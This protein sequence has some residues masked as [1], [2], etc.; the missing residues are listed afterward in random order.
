MGKRVGSD[1]IASVHRARKIYRLKTKLTKRKT[2]L[3][4][5][6]GYFAKIVNDCILSIH[7]LS[8]VRTGHAQ[9]LCPPRIS[10]FVRTARW[11]SEQKRTIRSYFWCGI[12]ALQS[13]ALR[14]STWILDPSV[15]LE[16]Q[17][18]IQV[19]GQRVDLPHTFFEH[20]INFLIIFLL[21]YIEHFSISAR[22]GYEH[23]QKFKILNL[24]LKKGHL[25]KTND[26]G[27]FY[28]ESKFFIFEVWTIYWRD[29]TL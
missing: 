9:S 1:P 13:K 17:R 28:S 27:S 4:P 19:L 20:L 10:P 7:A 12:F 8:C 2:R 21:L 22:Y 25:I 11:V 24:S 3:C 6:V 29:S 14:P 18:P 16:F 15:K 23:S 5:S 26:L